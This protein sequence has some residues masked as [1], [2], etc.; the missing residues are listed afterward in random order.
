VVKKGSGILSE[1]ADPT[2]T[3][4]NSVS[5]KLQKTAWEIF[6]YLYVEER[7]INLT[8]SKI[9]LSG[10]DILKAIPTVSGVTLKWCRLINRVIYGSGE[11][12]LPWIAT[13]RKPVNLFTI[14]ATL[15]HQPESLRR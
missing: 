10:T 5:G 1:T 6:V 9:L 7:Y 13:I 4:E 8:G 14:C 15:V 2:M 3:T 12:G 11:E